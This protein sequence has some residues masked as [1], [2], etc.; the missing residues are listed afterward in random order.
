MCSSDLCNGGNKPPYEP[1]GRRNQT[2]GGSGICSEVTDHCC[3]DVLD[4]HERN[5]SKNRRQAQTPNEFDL[6]P[7]V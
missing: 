2:D 1:E 4:H 7:N 3:V 6:V 5:L